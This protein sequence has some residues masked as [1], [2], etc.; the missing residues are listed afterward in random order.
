VIM[1]GEIRDRETAEIAIQA[2][3]TGHLVLSTIHTNSAA[4]V[5]TRLIDMNVEPFLVSS[6][7]VGVIAQRLVRMLCPLCRKDFVFS[8]DMK[9]NI[10]ELASVPSGTT[11]AA[12]AG[13]PECNQLGYNGRTALFEMF[14][15]EDDVRSLVLSKS[16]EA[17]I[18]KLLLSKKMKTLRDAGLQKAQMRIT[19]IEEVMRI[20]FVEK[21]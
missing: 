19:S 20:T 15:M 9:K 10:P 7:V 14:A 18:S 2:A 1:I 12:P 13:C 17:E 4:G 6:A 11:F 3:L 8:E 21:D 16:N 5:V